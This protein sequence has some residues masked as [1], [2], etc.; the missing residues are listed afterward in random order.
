[1]AR[2]PDGSFAREQESFVPFSH[3]PFL[4]K[5]LPVY[6]A[7]KGYR[8]YYM[9]R[10]R[11]TAA[12]TV[13]ITG[14]DCKVQFYIAAPFDADCPAQEYDVYVSLK[15]LADDRVL[16]DRMYVCKVT[17]HVVPLQPAKAAPA[18]KKGKRGRRR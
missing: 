5:F 12:E 9:G 2:K 3:N 17:G 13:V 8:P 16:I 18:A 6:K 1:M 4:R 14:V 11:L 15:H 7:A 10:V